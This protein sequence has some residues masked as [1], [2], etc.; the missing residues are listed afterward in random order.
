MAHG[1]MDRHASTAA[2]LRERLQAA[3]R[4]LPFLVYR[5]PDNLQVIVELPPQRDR[6]TIGR[7]PDN[8]VA[9]RWDAEVSR[10]HAEL[11]RIGSDW[12]VCDEGL[13][14][15]GTYVNGER[16]LAR[17]RLRSGDVIAAG[18][19]L[20]AV[21]IPPGGGHSSTR[22]SIHPVAVELTPAQRRVLVALCR[23]MAAGRYAAP[24]TNR[25]IAAELVLSVDTVKGTLTQLFELFGLEEV[26]QNAKR[27]T[28]AS[29]ALDAGVVRREDL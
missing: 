7:G 26:P 24:A 5:G 16:V 22:T 3:R 19:T 15:N 8:D 6:L 4:G 21:E 27:A 9:L 1:P 25:A 14:H 29:A 20:I 13:S 18:R 11:Q 10:V 2:E 17:R 12:A 28:L 23:P